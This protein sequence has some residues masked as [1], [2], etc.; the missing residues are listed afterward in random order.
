L[1]FFFGVEFIF[2]FTCAV[3]PKE[4]SQEQPPKEC[5]VDAVHLTGMFHTME[6]PFKADPIVMKEIETTRTNIH[7]LCEKALPGGALLAVGCM[8]GKFY[9]QVLN[10]E[11]KAI[12]DKMIEEKQFGAYTV[13]CTYR[14]KSNFFLRAYAFV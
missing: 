1:K 7:T 6:N 3:G 13:Y 12:V 11:A 14:R 2:F 4:M 9:V 5:K 8:F 10:E